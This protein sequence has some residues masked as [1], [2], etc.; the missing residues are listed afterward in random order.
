MPRPLAGLA[1]LL[2]AEGV[3]SDLEVTGVTHDSRAVR[4]GDLYAALPGAHTHGA[5]FASDAAAAGAVAVLTDTDGAVHA[6][7]AGLPMI[8]VADARAA[9]PDVARWVYDDPSHDLLLAG[10][11][12][13]NGKTTTSYLVESGLR[14]AGHI[15]GLL[16]T[17]E[18]RIADLSMPSV[19]T[20]PEA[21]DLQGA[22][23]LMRESGVSTAVMEVSSHALA[24]HRVDGVAFDVATFTNLSQ[25]HLDFHAN[26]EDYF[27]A[28][29]RL[30]DGH[31]SRKAVV[32]LDDAHGKR[33]AA[34][35]RIPV[36]TYSADG[37]PAAHWRVSDIRQEGPGSAFIVHGP[38]G[39]KVEAAT[40]L[41]GTFNVANALAAIVTLVQMGVGLDHAIRGVAGQSGVP[42]RMERV[43]VGQPFLALV[44]YAHTPQAIETLLAALRPVTRGRLIIVVGCGGDRDRAKRPLMGAA[45]AMGADLAIFT[46]DNPRSEDPAAIRAALTEGALQVPET[47]RAEIVTVPGRDV[48]IRYAVE[49]AKAGDTLVI[50]GKGHEQ[51]QEIEGLIIPFDDREILRGALM[52]REQ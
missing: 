45:A 6:R 17:V 7:G 13:T 51:G 16:G 33:L 32:N 14:A 52:E 37:D 46:D 1:A 40:R 24:L 20:T 29:A 11:T 19:R 44:D 12:G 36:T 31:L 21:S 43:D 10:I 49:H 42:G 39:E 25:D 50:A 5:Y 27:E 41:P 23:A 26:L 3:P 15:T 9:L 38:D 47:D 8:V 18:T 34:A 48:A 35:A 28:K 2:A 4:R 22:F 30:F